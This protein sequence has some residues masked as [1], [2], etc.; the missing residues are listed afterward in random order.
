MFLKFEGL[1]LAAEER[2]F[3]SIQNIGLT[4]ES[5]VKCFELI[6]ISRK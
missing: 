1:I 5:F 2:A 4:Y 3:A 6:D